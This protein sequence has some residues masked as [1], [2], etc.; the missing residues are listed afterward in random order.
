MPLGAPETV[1]DPPRHTEVH[2]RR[3]GA[4]TL[5]GAGLTH[6]NGVGNLNQQGLQP[7]PAQNSHRVA[8]QSSPHLI[9]HKD[10]LPPCEGQCCNILPN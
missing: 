1:N 9:S 8:E 2:Q 10:Q 7:E 5:H 4:D 3:D 6:G